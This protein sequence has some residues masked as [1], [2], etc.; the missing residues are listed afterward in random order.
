MQASARRSKDSVGV[1][2]LSCREL[3]AA[4]TIDYGALR[5]IEHGEEFPSFEELLAISNELV[6]PLTF[7][8]GHFEN[9]HYLF[10]GV[11]GNGRT[12]AIATPA[13]HL[14]SGRGILMH[15]AIQC[16]SRIPQRAPDP[17]LHSIGRQDAKPGAAGDHR[18]RVRRRVRCGV[19]ATVIS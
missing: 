1:R 6:L 4:T 12:G 9:E 2:G 7:L 17:S 14:A 5:R 18:V 15:W 16:A 8:I 3:A 11:C 10:E 19:S 13:P